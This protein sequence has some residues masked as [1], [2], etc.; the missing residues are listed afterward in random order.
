MDPRGLADRRV[1]AVARSRPG[2]ARRRNPL[3]GL[4]QWKI[5]DNL[6]R[7]LEPSALA[8]LLLLGWTFSHSAWYWTL[9]VIGILLIPSVMA[10]AV[11][12]FRMPADTLVRQHLA[13][14]ARSAGRRFAQAAFTLACLPYEAYFGLDAVVR[15]AWR[16]LLTHRRLLEWRPSGT[17]DRNSGE[18]L[19]PIVD[20]CGS[21]P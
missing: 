4:S 10:S 3:T 21:P 13:A 9:A 14:E 6:R 2:G 18:T 8:L 19:V 17:P 5:F 12:M 7:S 16:M 15:T 20:R 1:A 11:E